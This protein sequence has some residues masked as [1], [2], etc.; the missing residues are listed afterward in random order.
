M[1]YI[2]I[3]SFNKNSM[4]LA[5][6]IIDTQ[7][8]IL[9][10]K[11]SDLT[12]ERIHRLIELGITSIYINDSWSKDLLINPSISQ[13]LINKSMNSLSNMDIDSIKQCSSEL[14]DNLLESTSKM[15]D[16]ATLREYDEYTLQHCINVAIYA[17]TLGIG[18]GIE[19]SRLKKLA[20]GALLHDIG[21]G[22]ISINI[23][24]KAGKLTPDEIDIIKKHP[25]IGYNLL[26]DNMMIS[27]S[28]RA[29]IYQHH[30]NYDGSGYPRGLKNDEIYELAMITHVCDVYDALISKRS[31]KK[32]LK[33]SEAI[34]IMKSY[35]GT[36]FNPEILDAF[37]K[38]VPIYYQGTTV[39]LNNEEEALV[40][41]NNRGNVLQPVIKL[42]NNKI[43]DLSKQENPSNI[44]KIVS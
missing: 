14:V 8:H 5:K 16:I 10:S 3:D 24:N 7:G 18:L 44:L 23:I 19:Y 17:I 12:E 32:A 20:S 39:I 38:Y 6:D 9:V 30:E 41:K 35:R 31:Y 11:S 37:F 43:I 34:D 2:N 36:L 15:Y 29:I 25:Q 28:E 21:K 42:K 13:E 27:S 26:K 4:T 22:S 1:R 33:Y 40:V